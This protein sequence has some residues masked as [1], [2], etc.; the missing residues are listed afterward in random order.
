MRQIIPETRSDY[1]NITVIE[2]PDGFYWQEKGE[3]REN[4]PFPTFLEAIEDIDA[5]TG[6][7][8]D[9]P[10][11]ALAEA[12]SEFGVSEWI[13]EETGEPAEENAPRLE[14]H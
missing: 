14:Q 6:G 5:R 10:A 1:D 2:R 9:A 11:E 4:G 8:S 13:D 12:E 3:E 7:S